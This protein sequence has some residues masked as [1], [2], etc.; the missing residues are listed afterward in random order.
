[1]AANNLPINP[2][3]PFASF[4]DLTASTACAKR[5]PIATADLATN[6]LV[7]LATTTTNGLRVDKITVQASS[8]S[9]TSA[10][11]ANLVQ[12]WEWNGT[13]AYLIDELAISALTPSTTVAAFS[14]SKLYLNKVL[15]PTFKLYVS[16]TV[17]TAANTTALVV[18]VEGGAF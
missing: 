6:N 5:G 14:T 9:I 1:M 17:T 7:E 16:N 4:A 2:V 8:T 18:L 3:A 10:T 13:T 12:I 15:P 11:A